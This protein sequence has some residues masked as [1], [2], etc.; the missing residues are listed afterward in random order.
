MD[1][2]N[3]SK[4]EQL[5]LQHSAIH[6]LNKAIEAFDGVAKNAGFQTEQEL[7]DYMKTI[8]QEV[9]GY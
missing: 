6:T 4:D 2:T 3:V 1:I 7:Q 8:R 9:R 5:I